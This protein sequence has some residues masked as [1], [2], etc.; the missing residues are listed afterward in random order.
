MTC[1]R[2][3]EKAP[4]DLHRVVI[5]NIYMTFVSR[6]SGGDAWLR[7]SRALYYIHMITMPVPK[8]QLKTA[9]VFN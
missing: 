4:F 5:D 6:L 3:D 8:Q 1:V 2:I 7:L 9:A